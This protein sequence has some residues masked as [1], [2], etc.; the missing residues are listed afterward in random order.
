MLD[1]RSA[2][3]GSDRLPLGLRPWNHLRQDLHPL[4]RLVPPMAPTHLTNSPALPLFPT[5]PSSCLL[6]L[7]QS[8]LPQSQT[9][10]PDSGAIGPTRL[11]SQTVFWVLPAAFGT[12]TPGGEGTV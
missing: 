5:S 1:T 3:R 9:Q 2:N 12:L 10:A 11:T 4:C 6:L 8:T 7:A